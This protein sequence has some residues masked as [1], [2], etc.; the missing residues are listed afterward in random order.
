MSFYT[1]KTLKSFFF[2]VFLGFLSNCL[3]SCNNFNQSKSI[4]Y[5]PDSD[6]IRYQANNL[7][8]NASWTEEIQKSSKNKSSTNSNTNNTF[9]SLTNISSNFQI[10]K[11]KKPVYP[12]LKDFDSLNLSTLDSNTKS[13]I[14]ILINK[15]KEENITKT[16][17]LLGFQQEKIL[18]DYEFSKHSKI[19][20]YY[21]GTPTEN[22][23]IKISIPV[24]FHFDDGKLNTTFHLEKVGNDYKIKQVVFGEFLSDK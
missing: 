12:E 23:N 21:L 5:I 7:I 8:E 17:F 9:F 6:T 11:D 14:T 1:K 22:T 16:D 3:I 19:N 4:I 18:F 20:S 24:Q 2:S 15:I 10:Q 13:E